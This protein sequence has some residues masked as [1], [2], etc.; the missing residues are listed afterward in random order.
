MSEGLILFLLVCY[1]ADMVIG[2]PAGWPHPVRL[3]G[4]ALDMLEPVLRRSGLSLR[5]CGFAVLFTGCSAVFLVV[6]SLVSL[7]VFGFILSLY[8]GY[9]CLAQGCLL[10]ETR[11]VQKLIDSGSLQE[12]RKA[13]SFLVSRDTA[14]LNEQELYQALAETLSENYNDAFCAPFFYLSLMGVPWVWVYKLVS[15]MDSMWGYKTDK[16]N[17]LGFAG[18]KADDILAY[19]PARLAALSL[20]GAAYILGLGKNVRLSVMAADAGR[21]ESPNAGWPMSAAAHILGVRMGGNASYF[22]KKKFK[23]VLG[24]E[25]ESYSSAKIKQLISLTQ[26]G[27]LLYALGFTFLAAAIR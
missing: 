13:M 5:L 17:Q 1:V 16:W 25:G 3:I 2:D 11:K 18:A 7:P 6:T 12:A 4:R 22:G 9:A 8:L 19:I 26:T 15:T 21:M 14:K 23:P 27:S 24:R 10:H 20:V